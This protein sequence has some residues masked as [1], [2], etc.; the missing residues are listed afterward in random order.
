VARGLSALAA[1]GFV[2]VGEAANQNNPF[3]GGGIINALEGADMAAS[4]VAAALDKGSASAKDLGAY[5]REWRRTVGKSNEAFYQAARIFYALPD[6]E[7]SRMARDLSRVPGLFDEKGIKPLRMV[8]ALVAARP[9]LLVQ[10][11]A[12]WL[13]GK[14]RR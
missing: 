1:D 2:A 3:S 11:A 4:A 8:R 9:R 10:F 7:M 13:G 14:G 6:E 12:G 5:T